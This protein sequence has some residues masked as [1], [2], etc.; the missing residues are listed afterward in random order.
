MYAMGAGSS[1]RAPK[2]AQVQLV[3]HGIRELTLARSPTG[4]LG[5]NLAPHS[6]GAIVTEVFASSPAHTSGK[7]FEGDKILS[8]NGMMYAAQRG[9]LETAGDTVV[10]QVCQEG[11]SSPS[12]RRV[13]S[14]SEGDDAAT[15]DTAGQSNT[16]TVVLERR[17]SKI[18]IDLDPDDTTILYV[19]PHSCAARSG[20]LFQ[21]DRI[22]SIDGTATTSHEDSVVLLKAAGNT[23]TLEVV[24]SIVRVMTSTQPAVRIVR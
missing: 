7:I 6:G 1:T 9:M 24:S 15:S 19:Y 3:P 11:S 21:G 16:R 13:M 17:G 23:V 20:L 22:V 14:V 10:L 5:I 12:V 4:K 18:G 2:L 8:V